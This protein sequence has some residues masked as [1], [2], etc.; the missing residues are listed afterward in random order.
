MN[1]FFY[2]VQLF[3]Y[4]PFFIIFLYIYLVFFLPKINNVNFS[5]IFPFLKK[6]IKK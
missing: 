1:S 6:W 3:F 2:F 4:Y 5:N